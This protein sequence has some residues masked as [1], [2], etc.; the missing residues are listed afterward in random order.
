MRSPQPLVSLEPDIGQVRI[1]ARY[2]ES[3]RRH[4][5][6]LRQGSLRQDIESLKA[7]LD[8]LLAELGRNSL[9]AEEA[10]VLLVKQ[11]A[12][13]L[14]EHWRAITL[15][16]AADDLGETCAVQPDTQAELASVPPGG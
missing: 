12:A 5:A 8:F 1:V 14:E 4:R 13:E 11:R 3:V 9:F 15:A 16:A 6:E 2:G 10:A 7:T